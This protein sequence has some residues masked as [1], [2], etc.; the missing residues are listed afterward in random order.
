[1]SSSPT[2]N[3][4]DQEEGKS[5]FPLLFSY[6][7]IKIDP[8]KSVERLE[9]DE[10]TAAA[11]DAVNKVYIGYL[12][13]YGGWM[14]DEHDGHSDYV[15]HL[16]RSG[17]PK[18][19]PDEFFEEHMCI[20]VFPNTDH[21]S[22]E[23][24]TLSRPLPIGWTNCYHASFEVVSL[25]V[26]VSYGKNDEPIKLPMMVRAK[27]IVAIGEDNARRLK[28]MQASQG[29]DLAPTVE[30]RE[31]APSPASSEEHDS[32]FPSRQSASSRG[33]TISVA[34]VDDDDTSKPVPPP[35]AAISYDIAALPSIE[36]PQ[37]LLAEIKLIETLFHE[38]YA[39]AP[40]KRA[41]AKEELARAIEEA[42]K[43]DEATFNH[44][45]SKRSLVPQVED[46]TLPQAN[47]SAAQESAPSSN[48]NPIHK[49]VSFFRKSRLSARI[50]PKR[51]KGMG[52]VMLPLNSRVCEAFLKL[53]LALEETSLRVNG[54]PWSMSKAASSLVV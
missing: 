13:F 35:I 42:K 54:V 32:F 49:V 31:R 29:V 12:S 26:P 6:V 20:P 33:G 22:R 43:L 17:L 48:S 3:N 14:D 53:G 7:T 44:S 36:D 41:R 18:S 46:H 16:L 10:A 25:R 39:R 1:M 19:S 8:V 11:Q 27:H 5:R 21:P 34:S 4:T 50:V 47:P 37:D 40:A 45:Q 28:L 15:I 52:H 23:P 2:G 38:A 9:D 24:L 30:V 51:G